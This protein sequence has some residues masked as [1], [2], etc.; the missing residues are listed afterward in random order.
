M[1]EV[2]KLTRIKD[3]RAINVVG[4]KDALF[5]KY[6]Y[7]YIK[8][9]KPFK[10][11]KD[12][13]DCLFSDSSGKRKPY[14]KPIYSDKECTKIQCA[15]HRRSFDDML[16]LVRGYFPDATP[17]DLMKALKDLNIK[18]SYCYTTRKVVFSFVDSHLSYL[19]NM[20]ATSGCVK[21]SPRPEELY[22]LYIK[23]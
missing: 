17:L 1:V 16:R 9:Q 3:V 10:S 23:A 11:I 8:T 2:L 21:T 14:A 19:H 4:A 15:A 6:K 5:M 20:W 18:C 22:Q 7:L 12:V 13:I